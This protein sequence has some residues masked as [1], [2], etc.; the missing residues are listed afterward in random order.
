V[1]A[2][3]REHNGQSGTPEPEHKEQCKPPDRADAILLAACGKNRFVR[4]R[5]KIALCDPLVYMP[6]NGSG[7]PDP[8]E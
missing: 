6:G 4:S 5:E 3:N 2:A 1:R 8:Y 7:V